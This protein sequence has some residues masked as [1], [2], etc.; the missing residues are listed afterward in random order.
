[1]KR[2]LRGLIDPRLQL[3]FFVVLAAV[4]QAFVWLVSPENGV[5][6][7]YKLALAVLAALVGFAFD[8][9][10]FPFATPRSYLKYDWINDPDA[11]V[12]GTADYLIADG[13]V[14]AFNAASIRRAVIV[15]AFVLG[16]SLGL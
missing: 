8:F 9:A 5:V 15:A 6:I 13:Y 16:V 12:P 14:S 2:L 4:L 1:M 10:L 11:D 7:P 3:Y